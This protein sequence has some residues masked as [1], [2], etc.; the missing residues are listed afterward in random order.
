MNGKFLADHPKFAGF[1]QK[2]GVVISP[3]LETIGDVSGIHLLTTLGQAIDKFELPDGLKQQAK[4]IL[5]QEMSENNE[6]DGLVMADRANARELQKTA[7]GQEDNFSKRFIY[8]LAGFSVVCGFAFIFCVTY[9]PV[10]KD[11]QRF[12][13][14]MTGVLTTVV[15]GMIYQFF[16]GSSKGSK[17]KDGQISSLINK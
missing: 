7:L 10:P 17:D 5:K 2:A 8:Y 14:A 15:F 9:I 3:V 1:I 16:F 6:L 11:N 13:D 4:D 12:A